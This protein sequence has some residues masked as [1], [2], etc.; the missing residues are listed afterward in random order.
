[1]PQLIQ[2]E[3]SV[4]PSIFTRFIDFDAIHPGSYQYAWMMCKDF[5]H[6]CMFTRVGEHD[7]APMTRPPAPVPGKSTVIV[8]MTGFDDSFGE[9]R[10][11]IPVS[12]GIDVRLLWF[13]VTVWMDCKILA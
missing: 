11:L 5:D 13:T 10:G 1:M 9:M 2:I 6:S 7:I 4:R 3:Y 8:F 12:I